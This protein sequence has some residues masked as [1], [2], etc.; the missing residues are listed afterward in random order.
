MRKFNAPYFSILNPQKPRQNGYFGEPDVYHILDYLERARGEL[1]FLKSEGFYTGEISQAIQ[2]TEQAIL[3][4]EHYIRRREQL[5]V[6]SLPHPDN[7]QR[8]YE[9]LNQTKLKKMN[10]RLVKDKRDG[11]KVI[12]KITIDETYPAQEAAVATKCLEYLFNQELAY[13]AEEQ[14][15]VLTLTYFVPNGSEA[16]G[17]YFKEFEDTRQR[18]ITAS[19]ENR[20]SYYQFIHHLDD[21]LDIQLPI[22]EELNKQLDTR[23]G[24]TR[25]TMCNEAIVKYLNDHEISFGWRYDCPGVFMIFGGIKQSNRDVVEKHFAELIEYYKNKDNIVQ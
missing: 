11:Y 10:I 1:L 20:G 19:N 5:G 25:Y 15:D 8:T 21:Q 2:Q 17:H 3:N 7:L 12:D 14:D 16:A 13:Y 24:M 23:I 4:V 6:Y 22:P 18:M 9:L